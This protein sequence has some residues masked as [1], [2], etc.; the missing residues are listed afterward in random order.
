MRHAKSDWTDDDLDD[1][2]RPL[3]ARGRAAAT[4][5]GAFLSDHNIAPEVIIC[6][7]AVRTAET[8]TRVLSEMA[9]SP[10]VVHDRRVYL[11][12]P[13]HIIATA[14]EHLARLPGTIECAMI[15]GH[16]PGIHALAV[17]LA[18]AGD[19]EQR[20]RLYSKYPTGAV[21]VIDVDTDRWADVVEGGVLTQFTVPR[22]LAPRPQ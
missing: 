16:N 21:A 2:A 11:A 1:H 19:A 12:L 22:D 7:T 5:M 9:G 10:Q 15:V 14:L 8:L 3:N 17:S 18:K 13:E 20:R 4:R 6:S